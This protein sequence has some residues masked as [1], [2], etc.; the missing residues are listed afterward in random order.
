VFKSEKIGWYWQWS[1]AYDCSGGF[2]NYVIT[3]NHCVSLTADVHFTSSV[4]SLITCHHCVSLTVAL[5]I[6]K[7]Q[8]IFKGFTSLMAQRVFTSVMRIMQPANRGLACHIACCR[9]AS[10][11]ADYFRL[12]LWT[13]HRCMDT[14]VRYNHAVRICIALLWRHRTVYCIAD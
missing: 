2:Y 3:C 1:I 14:C 12:R 7:L 10:L 8:R 13:Y 6:C 9:S 4:T 5:V 11:T